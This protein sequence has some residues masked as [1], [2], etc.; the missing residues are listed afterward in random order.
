MRLWPI[1]SYSIALIIQVVTLLPAFVLKIGG[2]GSLNFIY[3]YDRLPR[4]Y[5]FCIA[6]MLE[7]H[8]GTIACALSL[9]SF[10]LRT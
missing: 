1:F 8:F 6:E 10:V 5:V 4:K 9:V 3:A 7:M 2:R